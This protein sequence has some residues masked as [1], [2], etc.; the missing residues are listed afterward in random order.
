MGAYDKPRAFAPA[1]EEDIVAAESAL[2]FHVPSFLRRVYG[3]VADGGFGPGYGLFP[4][5]RGRDEPRQSGSLAEVR[6]K[7][8]VDPRW[9]RLL[10]PSCDWGC[11]IWSCLDCRTDD[12][13]IVTAAGEEP[14]TITRHDL[15]SWLRSWLDGVD[16]WEEMFEP[17]PSVMGVNPFTRRPIEMKGQG[18]PR[19]GPWA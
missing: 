19:G 8:S 14:L 3:E 18:K 9:P 13:H 10:L 2:G 15:Q 1:P 12:G 16:L 17:A 11:A 7:L 4:V 6:D 5:R